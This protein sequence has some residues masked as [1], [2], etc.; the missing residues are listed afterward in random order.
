LFSKCL[1]VAQ[2]KGEIPANRDIQ[3]ISSYLVCLTQGLTVMSKLNKQT[4]TIQD[5]IDVAL[6]QL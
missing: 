3:Q 5:V 2:E 6:E 1:K 4:K